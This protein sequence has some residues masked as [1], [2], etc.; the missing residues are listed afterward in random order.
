VDRKT[1]D[2]VWTAV[3]DTLSVDAS[4]DRDGAVRVADEVSNAIA[5]QAHYQRYFDQE[6]RRRS[7]FRKNAALVAAWT[8]AAALVVTGTVLGIVRID[9]S[10]HGDDYAYLDSHK[11]Q[12]RAYD[13]I[14]F[15]Y[16]EDNMPKDLAL[17][18]KERSQIDGHTAWY[19]RWRARNGRKVCAFVWGLDNGDPA[20]GR[21]VKC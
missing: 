4:Y 21:V 15:W 13:A 17:L 16:G 1:S 10:I 11:V 7:A 2:R 9:N 18:S 6:A 19:T 8:S 20:V 3:V 12:K 5:E 14:H